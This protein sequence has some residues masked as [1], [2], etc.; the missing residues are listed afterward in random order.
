M[1]DLGDVY[2]IAV[3]VRDSAGTLVDPASAT[4]TIT[5]PDGTAAAPNVP[6]PAA[7]TGRLVVD[8]TTTQAGRHAYRMVTTSPATA[9][10]DMFE[11]APADP[12]QIVSL[13]DTKA[14]LNMSPSRTS[15]DQELRGFVLAATAVVERHVGAIVRTSHTEVFDG[16]RESVTLSHAPVMSVTSVTESGTPVSAGGYSLDATS[17]VL[18]RR[19]GDYAHCWRYGIGTVAVTY[20]AGRT[21]VP[22]N[23]SRAA[24]III[25]HMWET[26]RNTSGGRPQLGETDLITTTAA[27]ATYSIPRRALELLGNPVSGIA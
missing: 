7:E 5:L 18:T 1:I 15:D 24:L 23:V 10:T 19:L 17:G 11:V 3:E 13:A 16:G 22:A 27:G 12:G 2:R 20:V 6:L 9:Y 21:T 4:L 14:H 8:Y 25:R 26:Q